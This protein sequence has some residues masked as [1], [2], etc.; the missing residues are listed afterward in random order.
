MLFVFFSCNNIFS[1]LGSGSDVQSVG[2]PEATNRGVG[3]R[4]SFAASAA[5]SSQWERERSTRSSSGC[6]QGAPAGLGKEPALSTPVTDQV[7]AP[8]GLGCGSPAGWRDSG[9]GN[10]SER[11]NGYEESLVGSTSQTLISPVLPLC[12]D[13]VASPPPPPL[14][15]CEQAV[16]FFLYFAV[17]YLLHLLRLLQVSEKILSC[18]HCA[19]NLLVAEWKN[20]QQGPITLY[21]LICFFFT[22][23]IVICEEKFITWRPLLLLK[24][25]NF[26]FF[27]ILHEKK[28]NLWLT[29]RLPLG[30]R[31]LSLNTHCC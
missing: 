30:I 23:F 18:H 15:S 25:N 29:F 17:I 3:F 7:G 11:I 20:T 26:I 31:V 21:L 6:S 24:L 28:Q 19:I 5:P 4:P 27:S 12:A 10:A 16:F 1:Q 22:D 2:S 9:W 14:C 8:A 13:M